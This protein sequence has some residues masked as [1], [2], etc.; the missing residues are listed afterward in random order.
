MSDELERQGA[1]PAAIFA[2]V[3]VGG[4]LAGGVVFFSAELT[5]SGAVALAGCWAAA[6]GFAS[7][8]FTG[9]AARLFAAVCCV[10]FLGGGVFALTNLRDGAP[11]GVTGFS[12]GC[13]PFTL[14][15]QNRWAPVGTAVRAAPNIQTTKVSSFAPNEVLTVDGWVRSRAPYPENPA[16]WNSDA[17]FHLADDSGWVSFAG[18]RVE[19]TY[20][21]ESLQSDDGGAPAPLIE[22][23][24]GILGR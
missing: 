4:L 14:Y 1:H 15:S 9:S 16:P 6:G 11:R 5:V 23:C 10:M 7:H 18:V 21:D 19:P 2:G 17:W 3:L 20:Y 13:E 24:R 12:G 8:A 22:E